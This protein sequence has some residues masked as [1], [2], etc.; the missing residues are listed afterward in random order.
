MSKANLSAP[1]I[2]KCGST[3]ITSKHGTSAQ[4]RFCKWCQKSIAH[5]RRRKTQFCN[6]RCAFDWR[7]HTPGVKEKIYNNP[8][9]SRL[10]SES[11]LGKKNPGASKWWKENNPMHNAE[12]RLKQRQ[13]REKNGTLHVWIGKRGGNGSLSVPQVTLH[14]ALGRGWVVEAVIPLGG[15]RKKGMATS[16]KVDIGHPHLKIGIEVDGASH[17]RKP[18]KKLDAKKT[19]IL[20]SLGWR[21]LRFQNKQVMSSLEQVTRQVRLSIASK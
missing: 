11:K 10:I 20:E 16:Y 19:K 21:I 18:L 9:R 15:P 13:T 2:I 4:G 3:V 7:V 6:Q 17:N 1:K 14:K 5:K 8:E 12:Q